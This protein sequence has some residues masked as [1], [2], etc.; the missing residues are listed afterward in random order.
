[1]IS[2][3]LSDVS[4]VDY[5]DQIEM[6]WKYRKKKIVYPQELK[7]NLSLSL[8]SI[9]VSTNEPSERHQMLVWG[10]QPKEKGEERET[11]QPW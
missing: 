1:M 7:L 9:F 8:E 3:C 6:Q 4:R 5:Y 10:W 11:T 2:Q